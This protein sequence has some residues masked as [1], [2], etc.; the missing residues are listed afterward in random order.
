MGRQEIVRSNGE[1]D[2]QIT[3]DMFGQGKAGDM[4]FLLITHPDT[5][6]EAILSEGGE[7][8]QDRANQTLDFDVFGSLEMI[9]CCGNGE[10]WKFINKRVAED[11]ARE[12]LDS[13]F[14]RNGFG[15]SYDKPLG[16][17]KPIF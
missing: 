12:G 17:A 4:A 16:K 10:H 7:Q 11:L 14:G 9:A 13:A 1:Q 3:R 6:C 5:H 8:C 15:R 2:P